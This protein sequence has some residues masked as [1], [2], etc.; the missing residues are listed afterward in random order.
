MRDELFGPIVTAYVYPEKE[1]E[2]TL[3]LVDETAPY[4]LTGAVFSDDREAVIEAEDALRYTAG[5]LL[6]ERQADRRGGRPA[7][8]RRRAR[9]RD[10]RQGGLDVEPDPLGVAADDQG[11]VHPADATT[12]TPS[13][14]P[15]ATARSRSEVQ[16]RLAVPAPARLG[17]DRLCPTHARTRGGE[18]AGGVLADGRIARILRGARYAPIA[19]RFVPRRRRVGPRRRV[20][21]G[22]PHLVIPA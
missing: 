18:S 9:V 7:A 2:E 12:A 1:W 10:E 8:V 4:A 5:K 14:P 16:G 19:C 13:S 22:P 3:E 17:L 20:Q 6:R 15:T 11:D 21:T